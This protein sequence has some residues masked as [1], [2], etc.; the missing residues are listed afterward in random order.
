MLDTRKAQFRKLILMIVCSQ[1]VLALSQQLENDQFKIGFSPVGLTS[2]KRAQDVFHTDYVLG[3]RSLGDVL[4]R[5]RAP[6]G[7]WNRD[8]FEEGKPIAFSDSLN[9]FSFKIENR[10]S[11][12]HE[13]TLTLKG[14]LPGSYRVL[15]AG[16]L[17]SRCVIEDGEEKNVKVTVSRS[18]DSVV[19]INRD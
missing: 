10:S 6:G 2:L 4:V 11:D 13:T 5:Y 12:Q 16:K 7:A 14:L 17:L 1:G 3:G 9:R 8:G 18:G 19:T 15:S